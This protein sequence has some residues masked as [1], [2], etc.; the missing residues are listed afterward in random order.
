MRIK[1]ALNVSGWLAPTMYECWD[2]NYVGPLYVEIELEEYKELM[3][4]ENKKK[5]EK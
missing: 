5:E 4:E 3:K 1:S 2:C